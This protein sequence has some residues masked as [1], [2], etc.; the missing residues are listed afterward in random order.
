M[1]QTLKR[2]TRMTAGYGMIQ[3]AGPFLSFIFTPI[4]TRI[5]SP[6]D[7]GITDYL[8]TVSSALG[9]ITSLALP[10]A[11]TAHYNDRSTLEWKRQVVGSALAVALPLAIGGGLAL[12]VLAPQITYRLLGNH[13]YAPLLQ[14][15]GAGFGFGAGGALLATAAQA[16]LRVRWGMVLSLINIL[17]IVCGNLLFIVVLRWGVTGMVTTPVLTGIITCVVALLLTRSLIGKPSLNIAVLLVRSGIVLL[18]TM[19]AAWM[20]QVVDRFFLV[21]YVST[22]QLGYYS[23]A[24]KFASLLG[25]AMSPLYGAWAPLAMAMQ[26]DPAVRGQYAA[27]A[28]YL[29]AAALVGSLALGLFATEI[30]IV[31]TRAPYLPAA[32]YVGFLTYIYVFGAI[33]TTLTVV[34]MINKQFAA[35]SGSVIVGALVNVLLNFALIPQYGVWG[36]TIATV[37]GYAAPIVVLFWRVRERL[38]TSYPMRLFVAAIAVHLALMMAGLLIP[39]LALPLRVALKLLVLSCLPLALIGLG[40]ITRQEL[41]HM[42]LFAQHRF[43]MAVAYLDR[44]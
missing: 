5:L 26:H 9:T 39:A 33:S 16:E 38:P 42:R 34:G 22:T 17:C 32:P 43:A 11:L 6:A 19:A 2:L 21:D 35:I 3:W 36:A 20:L 7:Y 31:F 44:K 25:V 1:R 40:V 27:I 37:I 12:I 23:I 29:V 24:S 8:F 4:I 15:M 28:R 13:E 30:L 10:Q 18:P 41:H 14:L